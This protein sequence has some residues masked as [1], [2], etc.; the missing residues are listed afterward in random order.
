M[1]RRY[2][3]AADYQV[4]IRR[5]DQQQEKAREGGADW[6]RYQVIV[7]GVAGP[8]LRKRQA[9]L[10]M[11]QALHH[12]GIRIDDFSKLLPPARLRVISAQLDNPGEIQEALR[13]QGVNGPERY[14]TDA[15]FVEDGKTYVLTKMWGRGTVP[16]LSA[17]RD[18][19]A[20]AGVSFQAE[21]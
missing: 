11:V 8:P 16:A 19:F 6:T 20:A 1:R 2:P 17:L 13:A 18:A 7:D 9:V 21:S 14:F 5:K 3:Q 12:K 4:R 10:S 15:P